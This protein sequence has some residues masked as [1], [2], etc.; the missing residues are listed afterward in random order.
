MTTLASHTLA[1]TPVERLLLDLSRRVERFAL[2]RIERRAAS[3][4][5]EQLRTAHG[6]AARDRAVAVHAGLL[7]R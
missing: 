6:E 7:P 4:S 1:P 5:R 2:A 3:A